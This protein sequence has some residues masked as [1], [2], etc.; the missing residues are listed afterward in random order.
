MIRTI[1]NAII[2]D[3]GRRN[4]RLMTEIEQIETIAHFSNQLKFVICHLKK[5]RLKT[6]NTR[7]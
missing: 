5:A 2:A 7:K 1:E 4:W 3:Y 6:K